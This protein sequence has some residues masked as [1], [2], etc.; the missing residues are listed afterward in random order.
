MENLEI[1]I[2]LKEMPKFEVHRHI[3]G[4]LDENLLLEFAEKYRVKLPTEN[5]E[6]LRKKIIFKNKTERSLPE[7]LEC[8]KICESV[9]VCPEAFQEA[10]YRIFKNAHEKENVVGLELRFAPTNY[11]NKN[12]KLHEIVEGALDG[13]KMASRDFNM[14]TGLIICGIRTDLDSVKKAAEIAVNYMDDGVVG[15]DLAGKENGY[16]PSLFQKVIKP[17]LHNFLPV[18]IHAGEDDSVKSIAEAIIY[19]HAERIGHAISIRESPRLMRYMNNTRK[20][21]EICMTSNVDTGAVESIDTHPVK[22]YYEA[23][24]R[25]AISTDNPITS[26]TDLNKEYAILV[27]HFGFGK[28]ETLSIA[29]RAIKAA[30]LDDA[31]TKFYLNNLESYFAGLKE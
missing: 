27:N 11:V 29:K 1:P 2:W 21:L 17:I 6:E 4:S 24:L 8:I 10:T 25:I 20:A 19:L 9:L 26:N 28:K 30:F 14:Y 22:R 16:P 31:Q 12:S 15:F 18:T 13:I 7:Y 23:G 3:G 5:I